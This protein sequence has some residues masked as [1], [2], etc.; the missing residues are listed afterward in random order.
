MM[1]PA[2][3]ASTGACIVIPVHN[4]RETTLQCLHWLQERGDL[5]RFHVIVVDDGS[6]DGTNDAVKAQFPGVTL[7]RGNGTLWWTGA[8]VLGMRHAL[9]TAG[10]EVI[11]WL[12]DDC[13]PA[14]GTLA[15]LR[16]KALAGPCIAVAQVNGPRGVRHGGL[17]KRWHG[18]QFVVCPAD[19]TIPV[20]AMNGDCVCVPAS[21]VTLTGLPDAARFP[22]AWGDTDYGLRCRR[23]G[24]PI[25]VVG[26]A[27]C[28]DADPADPDTGSWLRGERSV[29]EIARS[30]GTPKSYFHPPPWW[31]FNLRHWGPWGAVLFAAPY[32]RFAV[33]ALLRAV[34]PV[35]VR[36]RLTGRHYPA[37]TS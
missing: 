29:S 19:R 13:R 32:V 24:F 26:S 9:A 17:L 35:N 2:P 8:I 10:A 3:P 16:H 11:F 37:A 30:F 15:Q 4:R 7:L 1:S 21:I 25:K 27:R 12:N 33:I 14:A 20:A 5:D 28:T 31:S 18:L 34:L 36:R 6:T 22:Q 23:M